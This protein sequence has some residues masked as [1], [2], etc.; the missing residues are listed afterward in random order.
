MS[1]VR[2][3]DGVAMIIAVL[4]LFV[5]LAIGAALLSSAIGQQRSSFNEQSSETAYSLAEA[6]LNAEVFA[7][8]QQW[9]TN[10]D[11]PQPSSSAEPGL[12][13]QL[14]RCEQRD[15]VLPDNQRP[16]D[17]LSDELHDLS[18]RHA[19]GRLEQQLVGV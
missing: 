3:E 8:S 2:D 17:L 5:V 14:Q 19:K 11:A 12:P 7:L 18:D 10:G 9:P 13:D 16:V 1:R 6:A 4:I 15:V